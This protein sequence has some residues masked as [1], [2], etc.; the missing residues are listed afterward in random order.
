MREILDA[1]VPVLIRLG[2]PKIDE[3]ST[4]ASVREL[5]KD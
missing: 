4:D 5:D 3:I 2:L 1:Q